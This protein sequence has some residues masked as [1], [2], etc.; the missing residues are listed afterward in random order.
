[1]EVEEELN[2]QS[3]LSSEARSQCM[4]APKTSEG[5]DTHLQGTVYQNQCVWW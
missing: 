4:S 3:I 2:V 1:M 5:S